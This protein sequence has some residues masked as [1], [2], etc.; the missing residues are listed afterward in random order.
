[1]N[2]DGEEDLGDPARGDRG[3]GIHI[4]RGGFRLPAG[5]ISV[6]LTTGEFDDSPIIP[7]LRVDT[8]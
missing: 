1:M 3:G 7:E 5:S 8:S 4:T 2:E 6:D